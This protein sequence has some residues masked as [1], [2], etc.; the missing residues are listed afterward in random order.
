MS[1]PVLALSVRPIA[2]AIFI[3]WLLAGVAIFIMPATFY[4][5]T[6]GVRLFGP[7]NAHFIRDVALVYV[8]SGVVGLYGLRTADKPLCIAAA[9]WS[10]LHAVF[11]LHMWIARGHPCDGIF[12]F[13]LAFVIAPPFLVVSLVWLAG[14]RRADQ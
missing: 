11:H 1:R 4:A 6:P 8:A 9:G 12:L 3:L 5:L 10:C 13:D 14:V 7:F 2:A